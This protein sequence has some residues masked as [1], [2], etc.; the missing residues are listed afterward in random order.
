MIPMTAQEI[1]QFW[2]GFCERQKVSPELRDRGDRRIEA[3]PEY[4]ADQTMFELLE[5]ISKRD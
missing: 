3:D 4:W 1:K 2:H 5:V